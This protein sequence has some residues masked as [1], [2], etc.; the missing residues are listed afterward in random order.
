MAGIKRLFLQRE[1]VLRGYID[2]NIS[3]LML[4]FVNE[5]ESELRTVLV[6]KTSCG[7][8]VYSNHRKGSHQ[9]LHPWYSATVSRDVHREG[10]KKTYELF[11]YPTDYRD[12]D[13]VVDDVDALR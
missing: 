12:V 3:K 7:V 2:I 1:F 5:R 9:E 6:R 4:I 10:F 11:G 13:D 8:Q